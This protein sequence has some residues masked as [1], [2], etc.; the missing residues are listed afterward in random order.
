MT[1][2]AN[3]VPRKHSDKASSMAHFKEKI[4]ADLAAKNYD[5]SRDMRMAQGDIEKPHPMISERATVLEKQAQALAVLKKAMQKQSPN[6][7]G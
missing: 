7:V 6:R 1:V 4:K 5:P 2:P 3:E